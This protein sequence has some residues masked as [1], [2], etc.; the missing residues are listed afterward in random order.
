MVNNRGKWLFC[1]FIFFL[2][3][4][5][6]IFL[7]NTAPLSADLPP[8]DSGNLPFS[9]L[10]GAYSPQGVG[11]LPQYGTPYGATSGYGLPYQ[12]MR[13]GYMLPTGQFGLQSPFGTPYQTMG[14]NPLAAAYPYAAA[15]PYLATNPYLL[16]SS[17]TY[18]ASSSLP[19]YDTMYNASYNASSFP[20]QAFYGPMQN[21]FAPSNVYQQYPVGSPYAINPLQRNVNPYANQFAGLYGNTTPYSGLLQQQGFLGAYNN[22]GTS[23]NPF[24]PINMLQQNRSP[25]GINISP[26]INPYSQFNTYNPY[27]PYNPY[28]YNASNY[29]PNTGGNSSSGGSGGSST[30]V[31]LPNAKG[32][33]SG[34]W[35]AWLTDPNEGVVTDPNDQPIIIMSG[36][37]RFH[38]TD[39]TLTGGA[40][41]SQEQ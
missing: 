28:Q 23:Y 15:N 22:M 21:M 25:Y 34:T 4:T 41:S 13:P 33:W 36:D 27:N 5:L 16:A 19:P 8:L 18:N 35:E 1:I 17:D 30:P 11:F 24:L 9:P 31:D 20:N 14:Y 12:N 2:C 39:Q 10:P 29:Y 32:Y 7:L 26:Y 6:S 37:I 40:H 38:I 3:L